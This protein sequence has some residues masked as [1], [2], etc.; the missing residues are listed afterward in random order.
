MPK[1]LPVTATL[2]SK[3]DEVAIVSRPGKSVHAGRETPESCGAGSA[4]TRRTRVM[5]RHRSIG[6]RLA[7]RSFAGETSWRA[8]ASTFAFGERIAELGTG[9]FGSG[10]EAAQYLGVLRG[11][12]GGLAAIVGEVVKFGLDNFDLLIL[13][14]DAAMT[15]G[16][17]GERAV[18]VGELK[19]PLSVAGDHRLKLVFFVVVEISVVRVDRTGW[20]ANSGQ[21]SRPSI[22]CFGN[23]APTSR[24]MVGN[25]SMVMSIASDSVPAGILPGHFMMQ[26]TRTPPSSTFPCLLLMVR[27]YR[28]DRRS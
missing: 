26:G 28:H 13:G 14:R 4:R 12:V 15:A 24:A 8:D 11:D 3:A 27:L 9:S 25:R 6:D 20:P 21:M 23:S 18:V 5:R 1:T 7:S 2:S 17:S 10:Q 16:K 22:L 19:L